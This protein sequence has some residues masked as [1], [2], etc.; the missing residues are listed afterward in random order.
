MQVKLVKSLIGYSQDQ[1]RTVR[2]LG[3]AKIGDERQLPDTPA[4]RGMIAKVAHVLEV[5]NE[6][7]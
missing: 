5:R 4:V 2:A 1:R 3:L 7:Q 6:A